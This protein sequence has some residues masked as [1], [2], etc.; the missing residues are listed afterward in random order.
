MVH[1]HV[2]SVHPMGSLAKGVSLT[3]PWVRATWEH[4]DMRTP[5]LPLSVTNLRVPQTTARGI[6]ENR[7][8]AIT[9]PLKNLSGNSTQKRGDP[10]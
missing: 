2:A 1:V 5:T 6:Q 7:V 8:Y 10:T 3:P 9:A 4:C